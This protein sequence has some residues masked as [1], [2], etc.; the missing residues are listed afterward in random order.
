LQAKAK[1]RGVRLDDLLLPLT[2]EENGPEEASESDGGPTPFELAGDLIGSIDS[3]VPD[4][5]PIAQPRH[6]AFGA[7]LVEKH[8]KETK[9]SS[10][11]SRIAAQQ[12]MTP[13]DWV[14]RN[15]PDGRDSQGRKLS[16]VLDTLAF[17]EDSK[18]NGID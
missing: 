17:E 18:L 3:S 16:E 8:H 9:R 6:T 5:D 10:I 14:R 15:F 1:A 2:E 11:L 4:P 12:N 7:Y 13:A